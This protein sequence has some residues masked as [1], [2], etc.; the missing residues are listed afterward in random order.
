[1]LDTMGLIYVEEVSRLWDVQNFEGLWWIYGS[2]SKD[3]ALK[4]E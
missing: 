3:R 1:M 2:G 4:R